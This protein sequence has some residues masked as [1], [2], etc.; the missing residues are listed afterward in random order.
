MLSAVLPI[1]EELRPGP[2]WWSFGGGTA[3]AVH[4]EHRIQL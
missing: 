2:D 3:L 1:L 4:L